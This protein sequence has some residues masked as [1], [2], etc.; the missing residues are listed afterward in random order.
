MS[1]IEAINEYIEKNASEVIAD[2]NTAP[3]GER[4]GFYI[5]D[6]VVSHAVGQSVGNE[7]AESERAIVVL[8]C[9]GIGNV[10][11]HFW[12]VGWTHENEDNEIVVDETGEIIDF[13]EA[14]VR[15]CKEEDI[16]SEVEGMIQEI[17]RMVEE[18]EREKEE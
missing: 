15:C 4:L 2:Y 6:G 8:K 16:S 11:S 10:G 17:G 7:I 18:D 1:E 3:F 14:I 5:D 9:P 13:S 12:L